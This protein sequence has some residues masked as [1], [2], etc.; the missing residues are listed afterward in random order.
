MDESFVWA[1]EEHPRV[2]GRKEAEGYFIRMADAMA[3]CM[4]R[5]LEQYTR[6][7]SEDTW[8]CCNW[9]YLDRFDRLGHLVRRPFN[10][11]MIFKKKKSGEFSCYFSHVSRK[12]LSEMD[13]KSEIKDPEVN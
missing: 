2:Y 1:D 13:E 3:G 6:K 10:D 12:S 9:C 5:N 4:I 11:S 8:L 7:L